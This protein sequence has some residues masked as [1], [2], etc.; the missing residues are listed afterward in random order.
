VEGLGVPILAE[1]APAVKGVSIDEITAQR[2]V[3]AVRGLLEGDP[4]CT[5][6]KREGEQ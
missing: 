5:P 2:Y 1:V 4:G 6:V 3:D